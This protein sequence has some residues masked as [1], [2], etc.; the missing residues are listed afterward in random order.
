VTVLVKVTFILIAALVAIR[1]ARHS[2]A[3]VRHAV[4]AA[5]F[6]VLAAL[7]LANAV[8]P[9]LELAVLPRAAGLSPGAR[10]G[11]T[12]AD[13]ARSPVDRATSGQPLASPPCSAR[14]PSPNPIGS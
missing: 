11:V 1:L 8:L 13:G 5:T 4:L 10:D 6:A 9:V 12:P 7:P 3:S 14:C 2:R